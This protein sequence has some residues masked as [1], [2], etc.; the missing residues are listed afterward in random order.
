MKKIYFLVICL[1]CSS[2]QTY[3]INKPDTLF[4][5]TRIKSKGDYNI[6]FAKRN[7]SLF[8]IISKKVLFANQNFELL[9]RGGYYNFDFHFNKKLSEKKAESEPMPETGIVNYLDIKKT[10]HNFNLQKKELSVEKVEPLKGR[11]NKKDKLFIDGNTKIRLTKRFHYG[12][13][14][15]RNLMGLYYIPNPPPLE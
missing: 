15:T 3:S 1:V 10:D 4:K 2:L 6:I 12:L 5:V 11:V 7:D 8:K 9:K 13:Y 14:K